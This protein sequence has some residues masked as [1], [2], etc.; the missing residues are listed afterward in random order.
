MIGGSE[1]RKAKHFA[2]TKGG[3]DEKGGNED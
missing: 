3:Q 2:R 1:K